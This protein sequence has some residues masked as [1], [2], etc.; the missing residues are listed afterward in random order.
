MTQPGKILLRMGFELHTFRFRGGCLNHLTNKVVS[1]GDPLLL[2]NLQCSCIAIW[3]ILG[4]CRCLHYFW[5]YDKKSVSCMTVQ[6]KWNTMCAQAHTH[7][8]IHTPSHTQVHCKG[9]HIT[10][11]KQNLFSLSRQTQNSPKANKHINGSGPHRRIS[12][13]IFDFF[14]T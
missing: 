7:T 12:E 2:F 10:H 6:S 5:L 8:G 9:T 11:H 1:H 14:L 4:G 13:D 3:I